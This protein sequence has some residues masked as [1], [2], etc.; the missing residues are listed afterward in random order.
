MRELFNEYGPM[1]IGIIGIII[2]FA[3]TLLVFIYSDTSVMSTVTKV[4]ETL[5]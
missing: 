4:I 1:V 2:I 3:I 5:R